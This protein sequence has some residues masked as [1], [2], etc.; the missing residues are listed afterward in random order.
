M[1]SFDDLLEEIEREEMESGKMP[2]VTL[3]DYDIIVV[4][5]SGG[6]DS[7]LMTHTIVEQAKAEGVLDRVVMAHAI[8]E[9]E[10]KGTLELVQSHADHYGLRLEVEK[11]TQGSLLDHVQSRGMWPSPTAR[12][13]TSD[14]KRAQIE[15]IFTRLVREI[16]ATGRKSAVNILNCMGMRADESPGRKKLPVLGPGRSSNGRRKITNYLPI[17]KV[18]DK[19]AYDSLDILPTDPH[20]CY[21]CGIKRASC[22]V[23]IYAPVHQIQRAVMLPENRPL[24]ERYLDIESEIDHTFTQEFSLREIEDRI[25]AGEDVTVEDDGKWNM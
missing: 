25:Q 1:V 4:N 10:W 15:K 6:K 23:C 21:G 17:H 16:R 18:P 2:E 12:Y 22:V 11:R 3:A 24:W 8:M 9:E 20:Q 5:S 14:H 19:E 13:C 7:A